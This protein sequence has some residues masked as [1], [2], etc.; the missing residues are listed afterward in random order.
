L[1]P[2]ISEFGGQ[3]FGLAFQAWAVYQRVVLRLPYTAITRTIEDLFS[4][5]VTEATIVNFIHR[6]STYYTSTE[7]TIVKRILTGP[8]I[9]VDETT[10][11]IRGLNNY[12]WVLTNGTH[13]AFRLTETRETSF[14]EELLNG[15]KGV[16][17]S[18][19][20][21]GYDA[22]QSKQQKCLAHLIRD[23]NE[24]LWKNPYNDEFE[25]FV[26]SVSELLTP[27]FK[28]VEKF[29]LK[30]RNLR[31]HVGGVERFYR[32][33]VDHQS[34]KCEVVAKY[35]KRFVRY[36]ESL[37]TFL[38]QDGIPWNNNAAERAIRH[39]AVQRKISGSFYQRIA[40]EYLRLLGIGQT[41]RFQDKSF[42][43]FLVSGKKDVD[44]FRDRKRRSSSKRVD[45]ETV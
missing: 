21:G 36:R 1:P 29:S 13:V 38:Q 35:Q 26:T 5:S 28:D 6:L 4:E 40:V 34:S 27:I 23:L 37:F 20:Y 41:C 45:K 10:I 42:L 2:A 25:A 3:F 8:F 12:V 17:V 32:N 7:R 24:D 16:V 18:D 9:H 19:F 11:S 39:L 31:K 22:L 15:Y 43:R 14:V 44:S 33:N 30:A